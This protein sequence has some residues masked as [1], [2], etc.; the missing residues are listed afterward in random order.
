MS[1]WPRP[2]TAGST[3]VN[4]SRSS[5]APA[6]RKVL[7]Q[8][9]AVGEL[10]GA[11]VSEHGG[12]PGWQPNM[13][14]PLLVTVPLDLEAVAR[15]RSPRD[16][17]PCRP[18]VRDHQREAR[19]R[20]GHDFLWSLAG[21]R[22]RS[23]REGQLED[24]PA[25]LRLPQCH[26]RA[27]EFLMRRQRGSGRRQDAPAGHASGPPFRPCESVGCVLART[28]FRRSNL[29]SRRVRASTHPTDSRC[30]TA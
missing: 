27:I 30:R 16:G 12:Y 13:A 3:I 7:D 20:R 21:R 8:I 24:G 5:V 9:R 1:P 22:T 17:R 4:S 10:G 25:F 19:R 29:R 14:S 11:Q 2:P 15:H 23:R 18:R 28:P 6:L 26:T